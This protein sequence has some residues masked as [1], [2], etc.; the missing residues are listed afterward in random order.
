MTLRVGLIGC[1]AIGAWH[2]RI[3]CER[4]G[5]TLGVCDIAA[6]QA[7]LRR[8]GAAAFTDAGAILTEV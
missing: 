6:A 3:V 2:A 1:S 5:T 4:P 7:E 8:F